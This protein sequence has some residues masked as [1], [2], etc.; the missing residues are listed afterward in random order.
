[1]QGMS[2][3]QYDGTAR[4]L[5]VNTT[6]LTVWGAS[7]VLLVVRPASRLAFESIDLVAGVT[8]LG[9]DAAFLYFGVVLSSPCRFLRA[10]IHLGCSV[11]DDSCFVNSI[12]PSAVGC[13]KE[14]PSVPQCYL[15]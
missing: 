2:L 7:V 5:L 14:V 3:P 15:V 11:L 6:C 13:P 1:M 12:V 8:S 10:M 4:M 9:P